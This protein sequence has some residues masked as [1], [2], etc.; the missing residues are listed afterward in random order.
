M[1][2]PSNGGRMDVGRIMGMASTLL[3][4]LALFF[5]AGPVS[6]A[7]EDRNSVDIGVLAYR[8]HE[9]A[10]KNWSPTAE[11]LSSAIRGYAFRVIP[12]SL[13][14]LR[15]ATREGTVDFVLTNTGHYVDLEARFGI[16]RITTLKRFS[17]AGTRNM[18]GA[19]IFTR[20][21]RTDIQELEDLRGKSFVAVASG[22]FGG[23]Q[24]AWREMKA[25]GLDP[26]SDLS[27]LTFLG[28]PQDRMVYAVRDGEADAGTVRT[29]V[30]ETMAAEG[31]IDGAA[32]RILNRRSVPGYRF[33]L[34][35]RLY[36]EWPFAKL[37]Q[38]PEDLAERVAV[39]L[40]NMADDDPAATAG[41]YSGW[42]V[43]LDYQPVHEMFRELRIGPYGRR[44]VGLGAFVQQYWA[45]VAAAAVIVV[46]IVLYGVRTGTRAGRSRRQ[47]S[48]INTEL[49]R[50]IAER[51]QAED[52]IRRRQ[53]ALARVA[54]GQAPGD[55]A[56]GADLEGLLGR[57][58]PRQ[59]QVL[60]LIVAGHPN[61]RV[62]HR[63]GISEKTVEAH[64]AQVM[65]KMEARSFAD[66]VQKVVK[67]GPGRDREST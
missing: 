62:A 57:L 39:E 18:F 31:Q 7:S 55:A 38:T 8:G 46:V 26:F 34:S 15:R 45:G 58:T 51:R 22:A 43:P 37:R 49:E 30:L 60:D 23:F 24:M 29:G 42:T 59:R 65:E 41:D 3:S 9:R 53:T 63:L 5:L 10:T 66:L 6:A 28:F 19:V 48:R 2:V 67:T 13:D 16:S 4:F 27:K 25:G 54:P 11:Y 14:D 1:M 64:R 40:L 33:M 61:K 12:L 56:A 20:A 35:T 52:R 32:F 21:D 47:L 50:Q 44:P 17:G 36:P